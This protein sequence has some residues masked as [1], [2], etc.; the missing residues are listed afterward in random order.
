MVKIEE[1]EVENEDYG[2]EEEGESDNTFESFEYLSLQPN[3]ILSV[4]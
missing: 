2:Q 4:F 3:E 1:G